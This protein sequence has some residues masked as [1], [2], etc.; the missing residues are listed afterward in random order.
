[1]NDTIEEE[2]E[3]EVSNP[4]SESSLSEYFNSLVKRQFGNV[5]NLYGNILYYWYRG[6][7]AYYFFFFKGKSPDTSGTEH[8]YRHMD[9]D[10]YAALE[11]EL[12]QD[13]TNADRKRLSAE[14]DLAALRARDV[15]KKDQAAHNIL[16]GKVKAVIKEKRKEMEELD[17]R[18][19]KLDYKRM[20]YDV[21]N[22][23]C[24]C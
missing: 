18:M 9:S 12:S 7:Y 15:P 8:D 11:D 23:N 10:Q 1:M 17:A 6:I 22:D 21:V 20:K 19:E 13:N 16:V 14:R 4:D 2:P 5:N 3:D 24:N